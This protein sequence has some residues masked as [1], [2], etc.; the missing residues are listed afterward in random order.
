MANSTALIFIKPTVAINRGDT[1]I[2]SSWV[3]TV[4][5]VGSFQRRLSMTPNPKTGLVTL[6]E[7]VTGDLTGRFGEIS[8][9]NQHT[10]FELGSD[11]NSN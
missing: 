9:F 10:D 5:G 6:P 3:C 4:D 2:F 11:S 8:L 7:V 1:F